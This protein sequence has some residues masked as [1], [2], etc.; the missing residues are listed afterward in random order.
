MNNKKIEKLLNDIKET[1]KE[2]NLDNMAETF[3]EATKDPCEISIRTD[4]K[5]GAEINVE[6]HKLSL[7][8]ALAGL[9]KSVLQQ[10]NCDKDTFELIKNIVGTREVE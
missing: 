2:L 5:G 9:E 7:L 10:L 8:I 1:I 3:I 4:N 6:G